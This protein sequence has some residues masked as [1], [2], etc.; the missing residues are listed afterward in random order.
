[1]TRKHRVVVP[2]EARQALGVGAGDELLVEVE[3]GKV[4]VKTRPKSHAKYMLGLHSS[5]WKGVRVE[6]YVRKERRASQN[7]ASSNA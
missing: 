7:R 4:L 5:V 3:K 1:M 2:K 6:E